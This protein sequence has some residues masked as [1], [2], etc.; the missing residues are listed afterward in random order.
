MHQYMIG[1]YHTMNSRTNRRLF[2]R[3]QHANTLDIH[4]FRFLLFTEILT[5]PQSFSK[6]TV[7]ILL[8]PNFRPFRS[9]SYRFRDSIFGRPKFCT[10]FAKCSANLF[11]IY[12]KTNQIAEKA[13]RTSLHSKIEDLKH[14]SACPAPTKN[15]KKITKLTLIE[16]KR[17][18]VNIK[19]KRSFAFSYH[20]IYNL[21]SNKG[22]KASEFNKIEGLSADAAAD[23]EA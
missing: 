15:G 10:N 6:V 5:F 8:N 4:V 7:L 13:Y 23:A 1:V 14:G 16:D 2:I 20:K 19:V 11:W 21:F 12:A 18:K 17:S 3:S 22:L 9:F